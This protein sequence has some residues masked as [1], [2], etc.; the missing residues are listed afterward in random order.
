MYYFTVDLDTA[1]LASAL[2][3]ALSG[4]MPNSDMWEMAC[5]SPYMFTN[6]GHYYNMAINTLGQLN[7]E[8]HCTFPTLPNKVIQ[9]NLLH[10]N[11]APLLRDCLFIM[12]QGAGDF[13]EGVKFYGKWIFLG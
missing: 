13:W 11:C 9:L 10:R 6:G 8:Q 5:R 12:S 7:D 1:A 2:M 3:S 4:A